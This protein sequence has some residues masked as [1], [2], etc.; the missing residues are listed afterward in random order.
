VIFSSSSD[1]RMPGCTAASWRFTF[2]THYFVI[3]GQVD[4]YNDLIAM[5]EEKEC[6]ERMYDVADLGSTMKIIEGA[7][8]KRLGMASLVLVC[9]SICLSC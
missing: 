3:W 1:F 9:K 4:I 6:N 2:A 8:S 5:Y 7:S